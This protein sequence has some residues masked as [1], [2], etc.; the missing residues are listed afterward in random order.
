[1]IHRESWIASW[2]CSSIFFTMSSFVSLKDN[3]I[4]ST[5]PETRKTRTKFRWKSERSGKQ[6]LQIKKLLG[7]WPELHSQVLWEISHFIIKSVCDLNFGPIYEFNFLGIILFWR[8]VYVQ[9][10]DILFA[11]CVVCLLVDQTLG[12]SRRRRS[13]K[14]FS[15]LVELLQDISTDLLQLL[16]AGHRVLRLLVNRLQ[17]GSH[18]EPK[19]IICWRNFHFLTVVSSLVK[20]L[21]RTFCFSSMSLIWK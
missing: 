19:N 11:W 9:M 17:L 8:Y 12:R 6:N 1:M 21:L 18:L 4:Y 2:T 14:I 10:Y 20:L 16:Q 5:P 3:I 7:N 15:H 13:K